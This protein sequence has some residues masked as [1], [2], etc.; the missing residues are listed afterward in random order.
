MH[1]ASLLLLYTSII[2]I[3]IVINHV[4]WAYKQ[5]EQNALSSVSV[6]G[7]ASGF[8]DPIGTQIELLEG[9]QRKRE[10]WAHSFI[11]LQVSSFA[12]L[13]F[14]AKQSR[15]WI[16]FTFIEKNEHFGFASQV[17]NVHYPD[18]GEEEEHERTNPGELQR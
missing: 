17:A 1:L 8:L 2:I 7:L 13:L 10:L 14:M 9:S 4:Q 11:R 16:D 3:M 15:W 12:D 5:W 6:N 18:E